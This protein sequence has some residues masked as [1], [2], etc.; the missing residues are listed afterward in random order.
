MNNL[1]ELESNIKKLE[2]QKIEDQY[3]IYNKF[4]PKNYFYRLSR[5]E[6]YNL[7]LDNKRL[8]DESFDNYKL[9]Q[10]KVKH[11]LKLRSIN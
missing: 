10:K 8:Q 7:S 6:F 9:R 5:E 3:D 2:P 4:I 1:E 11:Y